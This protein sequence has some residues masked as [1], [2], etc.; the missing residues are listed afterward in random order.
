MNRESKYRLP[1]GQ[2][3]GHPWDI[4]HRMRLERLNGSYEYKLERGVSYFV[5]KLES[6]GCKT[7]WSC[8]GHPAGFYV[9]FMADP[10]VAIKVAKSLH[11]TIGE[12]SV[13]HVLDSDQ[14]KSVNAEKGVDPNTFQQGWK[15]AMRSN[16]LRSFGTR[17]SQLR[18]MAEALDTLK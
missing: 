7:M 5:N 10:K 13:A 17:N 15:L 14:M 16:R 12:V 2:L 8:E 18:K 1:A 6:L 4:H 3:D 9:I 11:Y